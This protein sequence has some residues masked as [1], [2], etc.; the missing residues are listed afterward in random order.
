MIFIVIEKLPIRTNQ[1]PKNIFKQE[2]KPFKHFCLSKLLEKFLKN[3]FYKMEL[4]KILCG[5]KYF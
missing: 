2:S 3:I 1:Q 4:Q 5:A